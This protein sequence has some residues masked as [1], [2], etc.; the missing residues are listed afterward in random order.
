M[1]GRPTV[2]KVSRRPTALASPTSTP[3]P[4]THYKRV[5][6][7]GG[8]HHLVALKHSKCSKLSEALQE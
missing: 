2:A 7:L 4:S 1:D 5:V 3:M 8:D 6:V